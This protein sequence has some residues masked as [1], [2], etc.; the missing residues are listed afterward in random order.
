MSRLRLVGESEITE[1][2]WTM[3]RSADVDARVVMQAE[4]GD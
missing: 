3:V 4:K 2:P 1:R